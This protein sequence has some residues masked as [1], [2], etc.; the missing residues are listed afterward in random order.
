[1]LC[2]EFEI[3]VPLFSL[4]YF[5]KYNTAL[6]NRN[7]LFSS[8][9]LFLF[10]SREYTSCEMTTDL[11]VTTEQGK[12]RGKTWLD[13][14]GGSFY[15]FTGIPYAKAPIGPLRFKVRDQTIQHL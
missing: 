13:Y 12:V 10:Q 8:K 5:S 14:H 9:T 15:A 2:W 4:S 11:I 1:M 7:A 6:L 3:R